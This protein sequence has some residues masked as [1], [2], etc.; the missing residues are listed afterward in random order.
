MPFETKEGQGGLFVND[1]K[2]TE[3]QPDYRGNVRV[4]GVLYRVSGWRREGQ[5]GKAWLSL[6]LQPDQQQQSAAAK[7]AAAA[8][9]T[10]SGAPELEYRSWPVWRDRDPQPWR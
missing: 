10:A 9:V 4:G 7:P 2:E 1:R 8:G 3:A 5:S 6:R